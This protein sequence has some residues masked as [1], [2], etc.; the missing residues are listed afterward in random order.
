MFDGSVA[1]LMGAALGTTDASSAVGMARSAL[2]LLVLS[3]AAFV[4]AKS[5]GIGGDLIGDA[6]FIWARRLSGS[7]SGSGSGDSG[8]GEPSPSAPPPPP[9]A[10]PPSPES[11]PPL[12]VTPPPVAPPPSPRPLSPPL[13][14]LKEGE[15]TIEVQKKTLSQTVTIAGTV[16]AWQPGSANVDN[17]VTAYMSNIMPNIDYNDPKNGVTVSTSVTSGSVAITTFVDIVAVPDA[18]IAFNTLVSTAQNGAAAVA[19]MPVAALSTALAVQ[20]LTTASA[21]AVATA[22]ATLVSG[23]PPPMSPPPPPPPPSPSPAPPPPPSPPNPPPS[24]PPL[25]DV[26]GCT[27]M[28]N[29]V[30]TSWLAQDICVKMEGPNKVCRP[31]GDGLT[32]HSPCYVEGGYSNINGS[33]C[34]DE[35]GRWRDKKCAKK[36]TKGKCWKKRVRK[37][38]PVTC[39]MCSAGR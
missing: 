31:C 9:P 1:A 32:D 8:S 6:D 12:P 7:G 34:E 18:P 10:A 22:T 28:F 25:A 27:V 5:D 39:G 3:N 37:K 16:A 4:A 29:G 26:C 15:T 24:P 21:P 38:C 17:Y 36:K 33:P 14:P 11:P 2:P 23:P 30:S 19:S 13:A 35:A 20:A